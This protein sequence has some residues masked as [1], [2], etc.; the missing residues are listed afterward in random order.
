M[1]ATNHTVETG[2][3]PVVNPVVEHDT[4]LHNDIGAID[5]NI[6]AIH[7]STN[8]TQHLT[9]KLMQAP[10]DNFL[11]RPVKIFDT[12]FSS[13]DSGEIATINVWYLWATNPAVADKLKNFKLLRGTLR[14]T[15][16]FTFPANCFGS[17]VVSAI[18]TA[19]TRLTDMAITPLYY[20]NCC[21]VDRFARVD[22]A[23][24]QNVILDLPW[25]WPSDYARVSEIQGLSHMPWGVHINCLAPINT[26]VQGGT[27]Y[28]HVAIYANVV[29]D[30]ILTIPRYQLRYQLKFSEGAEIVST[31]TGLMG[32][33]PIIGPFAKAISGIAG[34]VSSIAAMFGFTREN[35]S[36]PHTGAFYSISNNATVDSQDPVLTAG[37][38]EGNAISIDP[39]IQSETDVDQA[40]FESLFSRWTIVKEFEWAPDDESGDILGN[41]PVSPFLA[42]EDANYPERIH[43]TTAGY[44]GFPFRYWR[45]DMEYAVVIPVSKMHRGTL[46]VFWTST[47][48][49]VVS[50]GT[51]PT[52][53]SP[54][55]IYDVSAGRDMKLTVGYSNPEPMLRSCIINS[56]TVG[57]LTGISMGILH[58]RVVNPLRSQLGVTQ[59]PVKVI[60][61]ARAKPNMRFGL[62]RD[63]I[64]LKDNEITGQVMEY[65]RSTRIR[66]Q[67]GATG[68]EDV[69]GNLSYTLL[70]ESGPY[71]VTEILM[72]EEVLSARALMQKP[73]TLNYDSLTDENTLLVIPRN[74]N[75]FGPTSVPL[76]AYTPF[77]AH[78]RLL[79]A[80]VSGSEKV[81]VNTNQGTNVYAYREPS[82]GSVPPRNP[83]GPLTYSGPQRGAQFLIP[84]YQQFKFSCG[85]SP[86]NWFEG[87]I[88]M[89]FVMSSG[90]MSTPNAFWCYG[91]DLRVT[92]FYQVPAMDMP[93]G[94]SF[95]EEYNGALTGAY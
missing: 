76:T 18:P 78:Y 81:F 46:Q 89:K 26:A 57:T 86:L 67:A 74:G 37:L 70:D 71:P 59:T 19:S 4:T 1:S 16:M 40:S 50:Q 54:N 34:G 39:R 23:A 42:Y 10:L 25:F 31:A 29:D 2:V 63:T 95:P 52:N 55:I 41:V 3:M 90:A 87:A 93:D 11:K 36:P 61:F 79:F 44:V 22:C 47:S 30:F 13:N 85:R 75:V 51:D 6:E 64:P 80:A 15:A 49:T 94:T 84:N 32:S 20:P 12:D 24:S 82:P 48:D 5:S 9:Q 43:L 35:F 21:Q 69:E 58:F 66:Y 83:L 14:L 65:A 60:I 28:G 72:G 88:N 45:G 27:A 56:D 7:S 53:I 91:P 92:N 33:L 17:Y 77:A 73:S 38:L 68:D 8:D 62:L